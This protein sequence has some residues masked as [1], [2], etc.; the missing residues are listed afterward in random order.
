MSIRGYQSKN[1]Q[2]F[3]L[4]LGEACSDIQFELLPRL[5]R[6]GIDRDVEMRTERLSDDVLL[7]VLSK[8]PQLR[9]QLAELNETISKASPCNVIIDLCL[10]EIITSSSISNLMILRHLLL[11]R[12]RKLVLCSVAL[13]TK[14]V[15]STVGLENL[16]HFAAD[17]SSAVAIIE[18][19]KQTTIRQKQS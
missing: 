2:H 12:G 19:T 3:L 1:F 4:N 9:N 16:F 14:G 18:S 11:E 8:E 5:D 13:P 6:V 7:V 15:F 10:V 17:R